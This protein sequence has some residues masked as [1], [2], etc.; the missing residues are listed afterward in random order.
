MVFHLETPI[1]NCFTYLFRP[2]GLTDSE[3]TCLAMMA[4]LYPVS[5][6]TYLLWIPDQI[7]SMSRCAHQVL[8]TF[9]ETR[10]VPAFTYKINCFFIS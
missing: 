4:K 3:F 8:R 10:L 1:L 2:N 7:Y 5:G 9:L 6:E